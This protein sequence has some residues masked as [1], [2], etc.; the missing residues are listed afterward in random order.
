[1]RK[2]TIFCVSS[3]TNFT[4]RAARA[5]MKIIG[6][7]NSIFLFKVVCK[8]VNVYYRISSNDNEIK[9]IIYTPNT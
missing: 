8:T 5:G 2:I 1:M 4:L 7:G 9:Y 3:E 6:G